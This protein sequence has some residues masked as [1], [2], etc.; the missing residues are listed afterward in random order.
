LIAF[1][2]ALAC[3]L[4]A[5]AVSFSFTASDSGSGTFSYG[6]LTA[7]DN[8]NG[9]FT[10]TSGSLIVISGPIVGTYELVP[11][12]NPP[13]PFSS[14]SGAF[15]ADDQLFP[16][17][18]PTLDVYGPFFTGGGLEINI[19]N[20]GGGASYSYFAFNGS[21]YIFSSNGAA[22]TL[23]STPAEETQ[24]LQSIVT[25]LANIGVNLPA[26]GNSLQAKLNAALA[27]VNSGNSQAAIGSLK[28]FI[29]QVNAFIKNGTLTAAQGSSLVDLA[30]SLIGALGG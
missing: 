20:V 18:N 27:Y 7:S 19:W 28:D 30:S 15:V 4:R 8:G 21:S 11:N 12:P 5:N 17:Q 6:L 3:P 10:A 14:P 24:V 25:A 29:N 1:A 2:L 16:G 26:N 9:S 23:A 13:N 22:F